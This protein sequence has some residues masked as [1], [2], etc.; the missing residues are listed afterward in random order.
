MLIPTPTDHQWQQLY[1]NC[2]ASPEDMQ[3]LNRFPYRGMRPDAGQ[4]FSFLQHSGNARTFLI[5]E[6]GEIIGFVNYGSVIPGQPNAVGI[7][8]GSRFT[9]KGH[10]RAALAELIS[11]KTEFGIQELN[12]YCSRHNAGSI[13]L[14][15]ALGFEQDPA[16]TDPHD[17]DVVRWFLL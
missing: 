12:G 17:A 13:R 16:F 10:A 3:Y 15:Q 7:G 8:L 2:L 4:L 11:R 9:G 5:E 6:A 14:M 1:D